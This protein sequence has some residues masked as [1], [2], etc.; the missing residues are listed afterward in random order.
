M[1]RLFDVKESARVLGV[2]KNTMYK[3][4]NEG[5][6]QS[7]RGNVRGTFK[8][9]TKS[10]EKFLGGPLPEETLPHPKQTSPEPLLPLRRESSEPVIVHVTPPTLTTKVVRILLVLA[11][12]MIILDILS[13]PNF[14]LNLQLVRLVFVALL[15]LLSYQ[16]GG[17]IK[18]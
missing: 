8:I 12:V 6:V 10:L 3:Y 13:A 7:A 18:R 4:L 9:P 11:L 1:N 15:G 5:K 16:F 2:S 17:F 14:S